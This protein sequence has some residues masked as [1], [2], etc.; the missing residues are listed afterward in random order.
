MLAPA[1]KMRTMGQL[2]LVLVALVTGITVTLA[3]QSSSASPTFFLP[4]T[5]APSPATRSSTKGPFIPTVLPDISPPQAHENGSLSNKTK[6]TSQSGSF[7][8]PTRDVSNINDSERQQAPSNAK[9]TGFGVEQRESEDTSMNQIDIDSGT[10]EDDDCIVDPF[11]LNSNRNNFTTFFEVNSFL[12][13]TNFSGPSNLFLLLVKQSHVKKTL[14]Q[15][16]STS[17]TSSTATNSTSLSSSVSAAN[18]THSTSNLHGFMSGI[19]NLNQTTDDTHRTHPASNPL[20]SMAFSRCRSNPKKK[21]RKVAP[22]GSWA[23]PVSSVVAVAGRNIIIEPP[24]VDPVTGHVFWVEEIASE[25]GHGVVFQYNVVTREVVRWTNSSVDVRT[26]IHEYGGGS[27]VPYNDTIYYS[28]GVN[29][30]LYRQRGAGGDP[31]QLTNNTFKRYADGSYSPATNRLYC[32]CEDHNP[33]AS[34]EKKRPHNSIV[35]LDLD[36]LQETKLLGHADFFA[37]PRVTEDGKKLTWV[38][39]NHPNMPWDATKIYVALLEKSPTELS[40]HQLLQHGSMMMPS[41]NSHREL[42]YVHDMSGWWNLYI[43]D[44]RGRERNL[45]PQSVEVGWPMWKLGR[46]AYDTNPA[47]GTHEAVVIVAKEL[48]VVDTVTG[49]SS[50]LETGYDTYSLGVAFARHARKVYTVAGDGKRFP[51]VVEVD[52]ETGAARP[53]VAHEPPVPEDYIST[54]SLVQ[55][56]TSDGMFAYGH[57]YMPTNPDFEAPVGSLPPLL[58]R[59][60]Q[61]PTMAAVTTLNVNHQFFTTRGIAILDVDYRGSTGYGKFYRNLLNLQWGVYD[62]EDVVAGA[63]KLVEDGTVNPDQLLID[64]ESA[65]G[66]TC[67]GAVTSTDLFRAGASLYGISDLQLLAATS[68]KFESLYLE[69][70]VGSPTEDLARFIDRSPL[71]SFTNISTPVIFLH[72]VDDKVVPIDQA[73]N[74]YNALKDNGIATAFLRFEGEEHGFRSQRAAVEALEAE[75]YFFSKIA[76]FTLADITSEVVI[77]NLDIWRARSQQLPTTTSAPDTTESSST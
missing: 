75:L 53:L 76:N 10:T 34:E 11:V 2:S 22:Y 69:K 1:S 51:T 39:W 66:F 40:Y 65:G 23:S 12:R 71:L 15:P 63:K 77:D 7:E 59:S 43:I 70:L 46:Q 37:A 61:G 4:T 54:A 21:K 26:R 52:L 49:N 72:G 16:S 32:V 14:Q 48:R 18:Q 50:L 58:V 3:V 36:T 60:H 28:D 68:H 73:E 29:N 56:P 55:F 27:L 5:I 64:G 44:R 35:V 45:T 42:F 9:T 62:V 8:N 19:P 74:M 6:P 33:V 38:E 20:G 31:E 67:L 25:G 41:W 17:N 30:Q 13:F 57:L 47:V 24:R